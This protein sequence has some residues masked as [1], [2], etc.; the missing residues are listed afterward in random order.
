M[1]KTLIHWKL[2]TSQHQFSSQKNSPVTVTEKRC[3]FSQVTLQDNNKW[4]T[5]MIQLFLET[6]N[7]CQSLTEKFTFL[8]APVIVYLLHFWEIFAYNKSIWLILSGFNKKMFVS[9]TKIATA[10][11]FLYNLG[12]RCGN[13]PSVS[14]KVLQTPG[15]GWTNC[16]SHT[17]QGHRKT[18]VWQNQAWR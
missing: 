1:Q 7:Y 14:L 16:R 15:S 18:N 8:T 2:G 5:A 17:S 6:N 10:S 13:S 12:G 3:N 9:N 4:N 11:W